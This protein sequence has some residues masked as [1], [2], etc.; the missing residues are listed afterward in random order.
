MLSCNFCDLKFEAKKDLMMHKKKE[1][2]EKVS[3]C[4]NHSAGNCELGDSACWFLHTNTSKSWEVDCNICEIIFPNINQFLK[5]KKIEHVTNVDE[6]KN[7]RND[8]CK[9]GENNC[10]YRHYL[11]SMNKVNDINQEVSEKL[12]YMMEQ[13]TVRLL[14]LENQTRSH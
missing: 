13:F 14:D 1:H 5:H 3:K 7:Y 9:Y 10:W 6:C 11:Q 2:R 8:S 4:W 12:F